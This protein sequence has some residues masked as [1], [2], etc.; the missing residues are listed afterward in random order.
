MPLHAVGQHAKKDVRTSP[1]IVARLQEETSRALTAPALVETVRVAGGEV[2][3][4]SSSQFDAG[5]KR[6]A[7]R[8]TEVL[9]PSGAAVK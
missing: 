3:G 4:G 6:D 1:D 9:R 7:E 5:M 8:L 2:A